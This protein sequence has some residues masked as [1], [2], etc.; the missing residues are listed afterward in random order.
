LRS[1]K[2]SVQAFYDERGWAWD[3]AK[4]AFADAALFDD[5]RPASAAYRLR[6]NERVRE[7]LP[8]SGDLILDAASGAIQF[9]DYVRFSEGYRRRVC[10]DLSRLGLVEARRRIAGHGLFVLADVTRLPFAAGAFDAVVSLHTLYHVPA[11]EQ[12]T[13]LAEIARV[14]KAGRRA[15]VVSAWA[16]SPFD[17]LLRLP[18]ALRR[19]LRSLGRRLL[20]PGREP[21]PAAPF[22]DAGPPLYFYPTRRSW[23]RV[24]LPSALR[25]E[26]RCWRSLS[27]D[28]LR[29]LPDA[30]WG[31]AFTRGL[32]RAEDR[33][34]RLFAWLGVYPL[35]VLEKSPQSS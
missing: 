8:P 30:G 22:V 2:T 11:D 28:V 14:L 29:R 10:V 5:L 7:A 27:V 17:L 6:A 18:G 33:W 21:A 34:P 9:P 1:E 20:A 35:L 4:G 31:P 16:T 24:H 12:G 32:A 26:A 13:F 25:L 23:L 15:V 19:R 3:E